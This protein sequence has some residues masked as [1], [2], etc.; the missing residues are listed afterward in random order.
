VSQNLILV[1][2]AYAMIPVALVT[3][4]ILR[5]A[6]GQPALP[7]PQWWLRVPT[8]LQWAAY[9]SV[10]FLMLKVAWTFALV[11]SGEYGNEPAAVRM[12]IGILDLAAWLT[13]AA[14]GI[15]AWRRST[16]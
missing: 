15:T 4:A 7:F 3:L 11:E 5:R 10:V 2:F 13:L 16:S 9:L 8:T 1:L 14:A 12:L 6:A